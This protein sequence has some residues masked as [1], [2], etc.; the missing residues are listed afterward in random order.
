MRSLDTLVL[1]QVG[2]LEVHGLWV[3][4]SESLSDPSV[5]ELLSITELKE[6][7]ASTDE[8][9]EDESAEALVQV[10]IEVVWSSFLSTHEIGECE[11]SSGNSES[12]SLNST[13]K[14][15]VVTEIEE[16]QVEQLWVVLDQLKWSNFFRQRGVFLLSVSGVSC[17]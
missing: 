13:D 9:S 11:P 15:E 17:N 10:N 2:G 6:A 1:P 3:S 4:S 8:S 7:S 12:G 16:V 5:M 14:L